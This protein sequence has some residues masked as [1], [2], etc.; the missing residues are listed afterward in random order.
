MRMQRRPESI[1][2]IA[3]LMV[4][5]GC[6]GDD[7][8]T[9][10]SSDSPTGS[11]G[12]DALVGTSRLGPGQEIPGNNMN[13]SGA[14]DQGFGNP[15]QPPMQGCALGQVLGLCSVCGPNGQP[16]MPQTDP[17]CP[18]ID[19]GQ[20]NA[21]YVKEEVGSDI[22][23]YQ[24]SGA[25]AGAAPACSAIGQCAP[26]AQACQDAQRMEVERIPSD[27][28]RVMDGCSGAQGPTIRELN[29]ETPCNRTGICRGADGQR[30][31]SV[32]VPGFCRINDAANAQ[33]FCESG[34]ENGRQFC[35]FFV[36]PP[37]GGR[38]RC[39]DF[40]GELGLEICDTQAGEQ[41]CWNNEN[42][43]TCQKSEGILCD[44]EPCQDPAGCTDQICRCYRPSQ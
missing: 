39:V 42:N 21:G 3:V 9:G 17:M 4:G 36:A 38:T 25:P 40:C 41:C 6:A 11:S 35:E 30:Q 27:P 44:G 31:C 16:Q 10:P 32:Q 15:Q 18:P 26:A 5:I 24:S 7:V 43:S 13:P 19:C 28:C 37:G 22:I 34:M 14:L 33:F 12:F 23:C 1:L 29:R 20:Q 2:F 8:P